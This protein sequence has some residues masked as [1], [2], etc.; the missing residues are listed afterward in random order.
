MLENE[1]SP[2][3]IRQELRTKLI[4]KD[5]LHYPTTSSTMDA[6]KQVIREGAPEGTVIIADHQTA[7]RG[8]LGREWFSLPNSNILLSII[9]Y[10]KLEQLPRLTIAACLAVAQSIE[11]VTGLE[12]TVKWPND[13]L[14]AGKKVSGILIESDAHGDRVNY[15]IVGIALNI[16]LDPA[17]IPEI[18]ET[19]TSLNQILGGGVSRREMLIALLGEFETLYSAL[20]RDEPIDREW[21]LRLETLGKNIS[22]RCGDD[23]Q[24]GVAEGVDEDGNLLLRHSDGRLMTIAAGD[25]TLKS[26]NY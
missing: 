11:K 26:S 3:S 10:P 18:S 2:A 13:I 6:A 1:L 7:G 21:R 16:N 5:I 20:R 14:I 25:V 17:T 8:R 22:I 15:A 19:A 24:E 12:P 23:V 9:L 4:G